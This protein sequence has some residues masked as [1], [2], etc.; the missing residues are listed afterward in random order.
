MSS[1]EIKY[2]KPGDHSYF[3][4]LKFIPWRWRSRDSLFFWG[5]G[6]FL[7]LAAISA[8]ALFKKNQQVFLKLQATLM[9]PT[10]QFYAFHDPTVDYNARPVIFY[11][12]SRARMWLDITDIEG[13]QF[14]NRGIGGHSVMQTLL[15]WDHH[16]KPLL[17]R[18]PSAPK[19]IVVLQVGVND[20]KNTAHFSDR[21][22]TE[23]TQT[24]LRD[25]L[26]L[27]SRDCVVVL[28]TIFPTGHCPLFTF[29][30]LIWQH[31]PVA[32]AIQQTNDV[33]RALVSKYYGT[34][35]LDAARLLTNED[36]TLVQT[37]YQKDLL[38]L[39]SQGYLHLNAHLRTIITDL[40]KSA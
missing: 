4:L 3:T 10:D 20:L 38:H 13:V 14:F 28:S 9:D 22:I 31:K 39:N 23:R 18:V 15:R 1:P 29:H 5:V 37:Q 36:P 34:V 8:Y 25:L 40:L 27:A 16:M 6:A 30:R 19:P 35:L 12:D 7:F 17:A 32:E 21:N 33:L 24:H 26:E 11:G 2:R